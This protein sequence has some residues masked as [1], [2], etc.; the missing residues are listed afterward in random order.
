MGVFRSWSPPRLRQD[1]AGDGGVVFEGVQPRRD[2]GGR[3][4]HPSARVFS[5][6]HVA[7]MGNVFGFREC[8]SVVQHKILLQDQPGELEVDARSI[9]PDVVGHELDTP[10][11]PHFKDEIVSG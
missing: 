4:L 2:L 3:R 8:G 10:H 9:E 11:I 6:G 7:C 5:G 1:E